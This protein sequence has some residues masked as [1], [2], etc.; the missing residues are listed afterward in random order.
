MTYQ[1]LEALSASGAYVVNGSNEQ[2]EVT[3]PT[4]T[5]S[6]TERSLG[7]RSEPEFSSEISAQHAPQIHKPSARVS[8]GLPNHLSFQARGSCHGGSYIEDK[9][10][11][12]KA[13]GSG[14]QAA[15][16]AILG[17]RCGHHKNRS[18]RR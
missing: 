17:I 14:C 4:V 11:I 16:P 3:R 9:H 12:G 6:Q 15:C 7:Q 18:A 5:A 10:S 13:S 2:R 8:F 1:P